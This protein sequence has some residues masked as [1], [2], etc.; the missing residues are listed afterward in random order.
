MLKYLFLIIGFL[1]CINSIGTCQ[2]DKE[3]VERFEINYLDSA[4][5]KLYISLSRNMKYPEQGRRMKLE[6]TA[7]FQLQLTRNGQV[8]S[9]TP[10]NELAKTFMWMFKE[11]IN[12]VPTNLFLP[13]IKLTSDSTFAL[14]INFSLGNNSPKFLEAS[15]SMFIMKPI[16]VRTIGWQRIR[17]RTPH[18][19]IIEPGTKGTFFEL[20]EAFK[21]KSKV[22]GLSLVTADLKEFPKEVQKMKSIKY[23]DLTNNSLVVIP[24]FIGEL[25]ELEEIYLFKNKVET[26]PPSLSRLT[27][28]RNI[29]LSNNSLTSFPDLVNLKNLELLDLSNNK[30]EKL[31]PEIMTLSKLRFLYLD[32][33]NIESIPTELYQLQNLEK[34]HVQGNPLTEKDILTLK[35]RLKGV[36]IIW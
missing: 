9:M 15:D 7:M 3:N 4:I 16:A 35:E 1:F 24:D 26:T 34:V 36:E 30:I 6:G 17:R 28:L 14:P 29:V 33:N 19:D 12:K 5:R 8:K 22:L 20:K 27:K 13:L 21:N 11:G 18:G 10:K 25:K 31:P 2:N 32:N 23:I